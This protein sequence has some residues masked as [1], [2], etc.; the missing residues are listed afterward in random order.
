[1]ETDNGTESVGTASVSAEI[2][3]MFAPMLNLYRRNIDIMVQSFGISAGQSPLISLLSKRDGQNQKDLAQQL[4]VR[5]PS[6]TSML[7]RLE[8]GGFIRREKDPEDRRSCLV[9]LTPKG[10]Q[11]ANKLRAVVHFAE[12]RNL[13]GF[14]NE[15]KLLFLRFLR[16][17]QANLEKQSDELKLLRIESN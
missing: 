12:E 1:M 8:S 13:A 11:A 15:E 14:R 7:N 6:L 3:F 4:N 17:M 5:A 9:F 10:R 2:A 16:H